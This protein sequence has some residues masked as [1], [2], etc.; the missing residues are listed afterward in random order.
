MA[1]FSLLTF[2]DRP[3]APSRMMELSSVAAEERECPTQ[4]G[5]GHLE[6]A[7]SQNYCRNSHQGR[8]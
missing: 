1:S 3:H 7:V 2:P 8:W 4:T 5:G 6:E